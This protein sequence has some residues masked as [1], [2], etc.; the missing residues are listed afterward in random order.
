[1]GYLV[2]IEDVTPPAR[3]DGSPWT[4]A[5]I[6]EGAEIDGPWNEIATFAV[7]PIDSD[8]EH[9]QVRSFATGDAQLTKGWYLLTFT[10]DVGGSY[11]MNAL[12]LF[13]KVFAPTVADVAVLVRARTVDSAGKVLG[14]FTLDT[15]VKPYDVNL[16]IARACA[17][18]SAAAPITIDS[19]P[20]LI[21]Q[22]RNVA[23][24]WAAMLVEL[25]FFPEQTNTDQSSYENLRQL[26]ETGLA[27][28]TRSLPDSNSTSK[29]IYALRLRSDVTG[30]FP[31]SE[32]LP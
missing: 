2:S 11:K 19:E 1:M 20:R 29:G 18:V 10:D 31:T 23:A 28:L 16:L 24:L 8:P 12:P 17:T 7:S 6:S 13:P 32:L 5:T 14:T 26:F 22:A 21:L 15:K 9:P 4:G 30:V 25:S 27:T 3:A